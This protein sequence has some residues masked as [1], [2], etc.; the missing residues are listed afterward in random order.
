MLRLAGAPPPGSE[1]D[2]QA[3]RNARA[4]LAR[5]ALAL[6][7]TPPDSMPVDYTYAGEAEA[8]D[9]KADVIA[10]KGAGSFAAQIFVDKT[11]HR[12]LM[13]AYRGVAPRM[14]IATQRGGGPAAASSGGEHGGADAGAAPP[15]AQ[16]VDITLFLD[17]YKPVNGLMLPHHFSRAAGGKT[18]EEWTFKV[19]T[20]NPAFKPD[21]FS[22]K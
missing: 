11:T 17:D 21:T 7:L 22:I 1:A 14:Q 8:E 16:I 5:T 3:I 15:E 6:L 18:T 12:P 13:L 9:G 19:I 20:V 2:A 4:D 10:V